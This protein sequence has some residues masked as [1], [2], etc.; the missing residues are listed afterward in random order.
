M[1]LL[2]KVWSVLNTVEQK[3]KYPDW[4]FCCLFFIFIFLFYFLLLLWHVLIFFL[5]TLSTARPLPCFFLGS[6]ICILLFF[7]SQNWLIRFFKMLVNHPLK[8]ILLS[9]YWVF[10]GHK[11]LVSTLH[12]ITYLNLT[13]I[14]RGRLWLPLLHIM[15]LVSANG[16]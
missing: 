1:P 4:L 10:S 3:T 9:T 16:R 2:R 13:V 14:L 5:S 8:L 6:S 7:S 11:A 15:L 12:V